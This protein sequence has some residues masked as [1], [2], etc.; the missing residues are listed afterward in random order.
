MA[1]CAAISLS[2]CGSAPLPPPEAVLAGSWV[3]TSQDSGQNGKVFVFDSVG[4]LI[5]IRTTMGQTTFIDRNV[6]KVTWVSGQSAFI[7]TRDGLI[8]EGALNDADNILTGSMRTELDIIF[9]DDTLVTELGPATL[10]KQ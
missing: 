4:T 3:L 9:T 10:T 7:E 5:E 2:G 8:I 1:V 6:H